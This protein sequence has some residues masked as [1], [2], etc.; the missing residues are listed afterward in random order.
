MVVNRN[1]AANRCVRRATSDFIRRKARTQSLWNLTIAGDWHPDYETRVLDASAHEMRIML[2]ANLD[3][4]QHF[5]NGTQG[6]AIFWTPGHSDG[7]VPIRATNLEVG[8]RFVKEA[9]R[10]KPQMT[11]GFDY[12][13]VKP[14]TKI[15]VSARGRPALLQLCVAPCYGLC[16]HKVQALTFADVSQGCLEGIFAAGQCYTQTSRATDPRKYKC[17]HK[18]IT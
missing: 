4:D 5:A 17:F 13:D 10:S 14:R 7:R 1:A 9:S 16:V 2:L 12:I 8:L 11:Y 6:R 15:I 3:I 18:V